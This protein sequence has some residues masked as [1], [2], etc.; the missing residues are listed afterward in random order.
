M[1]LNAFL[2]RSG[3]SSRRG[4]DKLIKAGSVRLNGRIAQLNDRV[5][6]TDKVEVDGKPIGAQQGK[7]ILLHKPI[8]TISSLKDPDGR[9][10]VTD[11]IKI[12]ERI[13]PVGRLDYMTSG[14][15]I[16]TNDGE[17]AHKL[18][19][20]SSN[21]E[22]TY[23]LETKEPF[24]E[25]DISKLERG[26]ELED[27]ITAPAKAKRV[28]PKSVEI[29]IHQGRNRQVRRM[30]QALG[31]K[32]VNLERTKYAFLNLEGLKPG[33]WRNLSDQEVESLKNL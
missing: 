12:S 6:E 18:M 27:G 15:L 21:I 20:P 7:Y 14:L 31:L 32:L 28:G 19:H 26:I 8:R 4:A 33:E 5:G 22:K 17:L 29:T 13:V 11:L 10:K 30:V 3:I 2:A 1:R 9:Q 25:E 24:P 23:R 16:L